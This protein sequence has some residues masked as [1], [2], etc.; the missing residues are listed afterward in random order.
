MLLNSW[1]D[2]DLGVSGRVVIREG[3][4]RTVRLVRD[5]R[6]VARIPQLAIHLDRGVTDKGLVLNPQNHLSPVMGAGLAEP[7]AFVGS[8]AALADVDPSDVLAF[9]ATSPDLSPSVLSG[10]GADFTPAP[11]LDACLC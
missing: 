11:R 7:G 8:L 2:R 3:A 5:D 1:L 4:G 10:P 9:D 6:P